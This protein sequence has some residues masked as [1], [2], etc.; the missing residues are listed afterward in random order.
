MMIV[1]DDKDFVALAAAAD[2]SAAELQPRH[3][4]SRDIE[5]HVAGLCRMHP[6]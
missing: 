3:E 5:W 1:A 6:N 4:Y 2:C